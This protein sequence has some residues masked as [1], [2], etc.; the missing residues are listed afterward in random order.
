MPIT[1]ANATQKAARNGLILFL[2]ADTYLNERY[3]AK[4]LAALSDD[5]VV[6]AGGKIMPENLS[7]IERIFFEIFNL[8]I[9]ASFV[10]RRPALA[11]T[12]VM[13]RK[14]AFDKVGGFDETRSASEDFDLSERIS[15]VGRVE[16]FWTATAITS[17]RRL[18]DMGIMGLIADWTRTTVKYYL[19]IKENNYAAIRQKK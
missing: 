7:W 17:K 1:N 16:F 10:I 8:M 14:S 3:L 19:G 12:C 13:Y 11:G 4:M 15:R 6:A 5:T 9:A 18:A 2:D